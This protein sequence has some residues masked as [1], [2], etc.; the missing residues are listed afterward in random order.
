MPKSLELVNILVLIWPV[1]KCLKCSSKIATTKKWQRFDTK[2]W[3]KISS[4]MVN[5]VS[6][7]FNCLCLH[8]IPQPIVLNFLLMHSGSH[9][10][11]FEYCYTIMNIV[12]I[13]ESFCKVVIGK[14]TNNKRL[15]FCTNALLKRKWSKKTTENKDPFI[16]GLISDNAIYILYYM[17]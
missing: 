9:L 6:G 4:H 8:F 15:F 7:K 2:S 1:Q 11:E 16:P 3:H 12:F 5:W 13:T 10:K 17:L 14:Q